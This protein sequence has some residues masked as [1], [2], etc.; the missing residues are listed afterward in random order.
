[1]I[2]PEIAKAKQ[3]LLTVWHHLL[4][5]TPPSNIMKHL[6]TTNYPPRVA[7]R[8][9]RLFSQSVAQCLAALKT[10]EFWRIVD[11]NQPENSIFLYETASGLLW[12]GRPRETFDNTYT[13][14]EA[15]E[16]LATRQLH[17]SWRLP[18]LDQLL[19][20]AS[21]TSNPLRNGQKNHLLDVYAYWL[22]DQGSVYLDQP[23]PKPE[24]NGHGYIIALVDSISSTAFI[25]LALQNNWLLRATKGQSKDDPLAPVKLIHLAGAYTDSDYQACR[26]PKLE[27]AQFTDPNKGLWE[28]WGMSP[29]T[30]A[31]Q[32]VRAR[33]PAN[34]VRDWNIA[35]DFGTSSTVVA[36][37][38]NGQHEL[39]R[40]GV[41]DFLEAPKPEHYENPTVLEFIDF[42]NMLHAWKTEAYRP[43]VSWDDVRCSHEALHNLRNNE[44]NPEVVSSI[45]GKIKQWALRQ[46]IDRTLRI[47]DRKRFEHE[48]VPLSARMPVKGQMLEVSAEDPFDPVE[49]Y[50]WFLGMHINWRG[51]GL[52]LRYYMTFPIAYPREVKENILAAFRRGLQR[53]LPATLVEQP[54]FSKFSVEELAS[55]PAAYAAAALPKLDLQPTTEGLAYAVFDFGGGTADF[56]FGYYRLPTPEEEDSGCEVVFE[57]FGN[58][59]DRFLGGEN[60]LENMAYLTFQHNLEICRKHRIAFNKPLDAKDFAGSELFLEHTQAA[61]TNTLMLVARLR[62]LWEKGSLSNSSGVEKIDLI[63]RDGQKVTCEL[64]IPVDALQ[65]YLEQRIETGIQNFFV[66]MKNAFADEIPREIHVLLAGNSSRSHLISEFFGLIDVRRGSSLFGE[67]GPAFRIDSNITVL[68][69]DCSALFS[70]THGYLEKLFGEVSPGITV[71]PPLPMDEKNL[72]RPT[73]KTGV[74]LGLL[75]LCPGGVVD[76]INHARQASGD[77]APFAHYVGRIRQEKFQPALRPGVAYNEWHEVG[78]PRDRVFNLCHTQMPKANTGE[79]KEGESGLFKKRLDLVGDTG[80]KRLFVRAVTPNGIEYC[81]ACSLEEIG[82][83]GLL[84]NLIRIELT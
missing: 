25:E 74:A 1:M 71:H 72:Y 13:V 41:K 81:T 50:A 38:N 17:Y 26:L 9:N 29:D 8:L 53:S 68:S 19:G 14:R 15:K 11:T 22:T 32:G 69:E 27:T 43:E 80:G 52:F 55:E 76:V 77:Q 54:I 18:S 63:N 57:H 82:Q 70:R 6:N 21:N 47:I 84:E 28:L 48:F 79:L 2:E 67:A 5:R 7:T 4:E 31:E 10:Q 58:E 40:I 24:V 75:R 45:L 3:K 64:A 66:A 42:Q 16:A 34:D 46:G 83:G 56:D 12:D 33:N 35:I 61:A 37:D 36:Y 44:T 30:L 65:Q 49:L 51:R 39:L 78:P 20:F 59:G 23:A 73:G 60:L 62:P